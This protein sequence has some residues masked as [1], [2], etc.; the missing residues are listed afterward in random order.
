MILQ[1]LTMLEMNKTPAKSSFSPAEDQIAVQKDP[2][3]YVRAVTMPKLPL[4]T[5]NSRNK[6]WQ[7]GEKILFTIRNRWESEERNQWMIGCLWEM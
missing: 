5:C 1:N 6:T 2:F 3:T 4:R 7:V